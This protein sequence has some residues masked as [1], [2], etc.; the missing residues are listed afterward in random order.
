MAWPKPKRKLTADLLADAWAYVEVCTAKGDVP[1]IEKLAIKLV[2]HR[3]TLY[4]WEKPVSDPSR[5]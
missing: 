3:D 1:T 2:V 4:A 5:G